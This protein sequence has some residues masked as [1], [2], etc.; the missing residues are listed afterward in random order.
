MRRYKKE[1][2]VEHDILDV[3]ICDKC[4]FESDYQEDIL[5][6][7]EFLSWDHLCGYGSVFGDEMIAEIDLCQTCT[8]ELLGEYIRTKPQQDWQTELMRL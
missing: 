5:E 6:S 2:V 1:K 7:Q 3:I 8:M 4:G